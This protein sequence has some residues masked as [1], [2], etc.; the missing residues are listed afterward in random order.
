[1]A[2]D[3]SG[4]APPSSTPSPPTIDL[5]QLVSAGAVTLKPPE[6]PEERSH[7]LVEAEREAEHRR[8][9]DWLTFTASLIA[10]AAFG[11]ASLGFVILGSGEGQK[12]GMQ[13]STLIIGAV[14]GYLTGKSGRDK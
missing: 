7:R 4:A 9:K 3:V 8:R 10:C 2:S 11:L 6:T 1:M 5:N 13:G 12:W 14:I